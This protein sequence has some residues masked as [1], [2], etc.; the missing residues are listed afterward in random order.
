[1]TRRIFLRVGPLITLSATQCARRSSTLTNLVSA[2]G[3]ALLSE[4]AAAILGVTPVAYDIGGRLAGVL[5]Y[6]DLTP[7]LSVSPAADKLAWV[8]NGLPKGSGPG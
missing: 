4:D 5:R 1:M 2:A 7:V 6:S 3:L 8:K